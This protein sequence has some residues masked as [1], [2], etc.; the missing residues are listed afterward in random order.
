LGDRL[1]ARLETEVPGTRLHGERRQRLG[2]IVN[3]GFDGVDGEAMLHEL[4]LMGITVSTGSACSAASPGPSHVLLAMGLSAEQAHASVR[5]SLGESNG[6][7]DIDRIV[8]VVKS[9]TGRLRAL[10]ER[11]A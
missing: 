10:A 6:E 9:V 7:G 3:L 5:F 2:S 4:D 11:S 1:I 8:D